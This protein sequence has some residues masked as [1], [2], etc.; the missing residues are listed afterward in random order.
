MA[1]RALRR[2]K[3]R[4]VIWDTY[5]PAIVDCELEAMRTNGEIDC[6][7]TVRP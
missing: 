5:G 2:G 3:D 1:F 4:R 6:P 7:L